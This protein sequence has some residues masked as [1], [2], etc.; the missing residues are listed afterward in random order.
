MKTTQ[1]RMGF[2]NTAFEARMA[3]LGI[4][5]KDLSTRS[6]VTYEH[7]RKL[8]KGQCLPSPVCLRKL[9]A[10]LDMNEKEMSGRVEKDRAIFGFGNA[11][12]EAWGVNP[13][14]GTFYMLFPVLSRTE[15][16][17]VH[18]QVRGLMAITRDRQHTTCSANGRRIRTLR[19]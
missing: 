12:W 8:I 15:Q 16:E 2:F 5:A 17:F 6:S 13:R 4:S 10:A 19:P 3:E 18:R 1:E 14:M 11:A 7:I 9:S